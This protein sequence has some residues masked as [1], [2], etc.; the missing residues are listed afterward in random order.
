MIVMF[1][2]GQQG[3]NSLGRGWSEP[4]RHDVWA[5]GPSSTLVLPRLPASPR[6]YV[7]TLALVPYA[8][9]GRAQA[10]E[11][12]CNGVALGEFELDGERPLVARLAPGV[13]AG[14]GRTELVFTPRHF[15]SPA[16][17]GLSEDE[18]QLS[19]ALHS[20]NFSAD[21]RGA[22]EIEPPVEGLDDRALMMGFESLGDDCEFGFAQRAVGAEPLSLLRFGG[23]RLHR[24]HEALDNGFAGIDDP[25]NIAVRGGEGEYMVE[26]THYRYSYHTFIDSASMEPD[27]LLARELIRLSFCRR[28]L[29]E[30]LED[31][32]KIFVVKSSVNP[33]LH[34]DHVVPVAE[35][36]AAYGGGVVFWASVADDDHP[37]GS[38]RWHGPNLVEGRIDRLCAPGAAVVFSPYWLP[39]CRRVHRA[40]TAR[41]REQAGRRWSHANGP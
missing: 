26:Q 32:D 1:G 17:L 5:V 30:D 35:V 29:L 24:L 21:P 3:L 34:A 31:G 37:P 15:A 4:E 13:V 2:A 41:K 40:V 27:E 14:R 12:V 6:G 8:P 20:I 10:L 25:A 28:K 18:R 36:V 33:G 38:L 9:G 22:D 7:M 16:A 39:L 11:V 19:F 23:I